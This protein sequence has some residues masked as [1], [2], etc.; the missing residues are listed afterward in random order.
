MLPGY[1]FVP[2]T[3]TTPKNMNAHNPGNET[4]EATTKYASILWNGNI[5]HLFLHPKRI[6][7]AGLNG[8][9]I[10]VPWHLVETQELISEKTPDVDIRLGLVNGQTVEL[11]FSD[12]QSLAE[13]QQDIQRR[14]ELARNS[15]NQPTNPGLDPTRHPSMG[16]TGGDTQNIQPLDEGD[17]HGSGNGISE[18]N[19]ESVLKELEEDITMVNAT[20]SGT[21]DGEWGPSH[22]LELD[23]VN[24]RDSISTL[25]NKVGQLEGQL[26]QQESQHRIVVSTLESQ[27]QRLKME[28]SGRGPTNLLWDKETVD[29]RH[30]EQVPML[31][32]VTVH[33][34]APVGD[35]TIRN[36]TQGMEED[37]LEQP[38]ENHRSNF[39]SAAN[40][41]MMFPGIAQPAVFAVGES[42]AMEEGMN[43]INGGT[44]C[45]EGPAEDNCVRFENY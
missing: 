38:D 26:S 19:L 32:S 30:A 1:R 10:S 43:L 3:A 8:V 20:L 23:N 35:L 45:I 41:K 39:Q 11:Q 6:V 27:F 4:L 18:S 36:I 31:S 13:I 40:P 24:L 15:F 42:V 44:E 17:S 21:G 29:E 14:V 22:T 2:T 7:F 28:L 37:Q 12:S 34:Q 33:D 25:L 16:S 9:S 5:G